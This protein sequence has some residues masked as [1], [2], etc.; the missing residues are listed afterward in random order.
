MPRK[1]PVLDGWK[2][3]VCCEVN[4]PFTPE[5]FTRDASAPGGLTAKCKECRYKQKRKWEIENPEKNREGQRNYYA[6]TRDNYLSR[7]QKWRSENRDKDRASARNWIENNP[8][9]RAEYIKKWMSIPENKLA[10]GLRARVRRCLKEGR[11][12]YRDMENKNVLHVSINCPSFLKA[13]PDS[14]S[15]P[16]SQLVL[17][18]GHPFLYIFGTLFWIILNPVSCRCSIFIPIFAPPFLLSRKIVV[19]S[20]CVIVSLP[21]AILFRIL[22][23]PF[24]LLFVSAFLTFSSKA[25]RCTCITCK[26][27][28]SKWFVDFATY[29]LLPSI[30]YRKFARHQL[31]R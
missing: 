27:L 12:I 18:N 14:G 6:K 7:K 3:C 4:K 22:N 11:A 17:W 13:T 23:F 29:A 5:F 1:F 15:E 24:S 28:W 10:M 31:F 8:E 2:Q 9:K 19:T 25:A 16:H 21:F 30:Q 26:E 20:F